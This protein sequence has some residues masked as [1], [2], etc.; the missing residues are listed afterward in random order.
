MA[1]AMARGIQTH[2][3][4]CLTIKHFA[5]NNQEFNRLNNNSIVSERVMREIYLKR[6][7]IAIQE[8]KP[9]SLMTSYNLIN[10][11]H[12]SQKRDLVTDVLRSEWGFS[13]VVMSDWYESKNIPNKVSIHPSQMD[14]KAGMTYRCG[15]EKLITKY[16]KKL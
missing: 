6:F 5:Y 4:R 14:L 3:K 16:L 15:E 11:A 7:K 10:G 9:K 13:G 2:K 1:V 12:S 8:G